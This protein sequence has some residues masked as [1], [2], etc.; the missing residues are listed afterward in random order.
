M[1]IPYYHVDVF[2][3]KPFSGNGLTIFPESEHLSKDQMQALTREMRQFES[4]FLKQTSEGIYDANVFT[5]E[6][7]LDFAGHPSLGAAALLHE[8]HKPSDEQAV[9]ALKFPAKDVP[10]HTKRTSY[11]YEATMNQGPAS[12]GSI[13]TSDQSRYFLQA[14]NLSEQDLLPNFPLQVVS[15]GLPYLLIPVESGF[16]K[17]GIRITGLGE[18]LNAIGAKFIGILDVRSRSIRTWDNAGHVED[19]ATGSLAG[20]SAAYLVKY[21]LSA[22]NEVILIQQGNNLGRDSKLYT[23]VTGGAYEQSDVYVTGD[24][25][26]VASGQLA[27][28]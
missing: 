7:E 15:T 6:E 21:G 28:F 11:G 3:D 26:M 17:A 9:W 8:L 5:M 19:I 18:R 23:R 25:V 16:W 14:L 24:V 4:I 22:A 20:P 12:F 13:L 10:I 27:F 2:S 1:K